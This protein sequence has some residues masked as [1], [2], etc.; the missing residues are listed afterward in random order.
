[1]ELK[2]FQLSAVRS[3]F[4]A[5]EAPARDIILKSPTGSGKTIL[6]LLYTSDAAD[7]L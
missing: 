2:N 6:C 5:M 3:L 7:E 1:M 4:A